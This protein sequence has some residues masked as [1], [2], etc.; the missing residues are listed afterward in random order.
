[1]SDTTTSDATPCDHQHI[2]LVGM[3]GVGKSSV[4]R[5]LARRLDRPLLDTDALVERQAGRSVREIWGQEGEAAFRDLEST[6]LAEAL[7]GGI[8]VTNQ[9]SLPL[10]RELVDEHVLVD[11]DGIRAAMLYALH[12]LHTL[13]EGGGAVALAAVLGKKC[14]LTAERETDGVGVVISGGNVSMERLSALS[15]AR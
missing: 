12:S 3:M 10:I 6:A 13:V 14:Q 7:A 2:V 9:Y 11:E 1:M 8:G 4:G 5:A 15:A